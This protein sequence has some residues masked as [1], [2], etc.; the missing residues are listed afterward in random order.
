LTAG[1]SVVPDLLAI[2]T[3][4]AGDR[5]YVLA[6]EIDLGGERLK[7]VFVPKLTR[8]CEEIVEWAGGAPAIVLVLTRGPRRREALA[9]AVSNLSATIMV[10]LLPVESG[11]AGLRHL[12][13]QLDGTVPDRY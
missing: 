10:E 4:R 6:A 9:T 11:R 7:T 12:R 13:T 8:L 1:T 5:G 3:P 2:R